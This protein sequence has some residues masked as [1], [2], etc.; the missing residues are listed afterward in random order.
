MKNNQGLENIKT[1]RL[2]IRRITKNDWQSIKEIL[3]DQKDSPYAR[4]DRP[5]DT[6]NEVVK[7]ITEKWAS[8]MGSLDHMF[9]AVCLEERMIGYVALN[10]CEGGYEIGYCFHSKYHKKGYAR[11]SIFALLCSVINM[12]PGVLITAG[13]ALEN[14]PSVKL[15][16]SLGFRLIGTEKVSFYK[17]ENGQDIYFEGGVFELNK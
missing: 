10:K 7:K 17:D 2:N 11:E 12:Q 4:F 8:S 5:K 14:T 15:L 13:T 1:E 16:L 6:D 3:E 9:F